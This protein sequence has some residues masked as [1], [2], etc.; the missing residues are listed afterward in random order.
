[1][2][3]TLFI[4]LTVW[5]G[6]PSLLLAETSPAA[7][8]TSAEVANGSVL[9]GQWRRPDG[10]FVIEIKTVFPEGQLEAAYFNPRP[11]RVESAQWRFGGDRLQIR[12]RLNDTGYQGAFYLLQY[13][14]ATNKLVGE[15]PPASQETFPVEFDRL[16][17]PTAP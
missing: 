10:G 12:I 8:P 11:I 9:T 17:G 14:P 3:K 2:R 5:F 16:L 15:S 1:M 7:S 13:D 4:L 6:T